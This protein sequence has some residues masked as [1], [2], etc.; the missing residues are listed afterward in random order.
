[1]AISEFLPTAKILSLYLVA[2]Y[3]HLEIT[4]NGLFYSDE[5]LEPSGKRDR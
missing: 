5:T 3:R 4:I 2:G 1:M